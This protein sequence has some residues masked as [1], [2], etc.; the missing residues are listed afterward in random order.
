MDVDDFDGMEISVIEVGAGGCI[1]RWV[2]FFAVSSRS[3]NFV[4]VIV[5][6]LAYTCA[7]FITEIYLSLW[8]TVALRDCL[9]T[10]GR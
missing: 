1:K 7:V 9:R 8:S 4:A 10:I 5:W 6:L 2:H 3:N